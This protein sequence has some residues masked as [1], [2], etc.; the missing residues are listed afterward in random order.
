LPKWIIC[1]TCGTL[2]SDGKE[3]VVRWFDPKLAPKLEAIDG[4]ARDRRYGN[5]EQLPWQESRMTI[6][7]RPHDAF[8]DHVV[9]VLRRGEPMK[10]T[11]ESVREV[12]RVIGLVRKGTRFPGK[13]EK[14]KKVKKQHG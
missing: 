7:P 8:Y 10:I 1:G 5:D 14:K 6:A 4:P 12:M 3:I 2:T 11:P 13:T 9:G